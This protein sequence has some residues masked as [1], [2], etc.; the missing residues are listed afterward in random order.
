MVTV[1]PP[2]AATA[3][4]GA[5]TEVPPNESFFLSLWSNLQNN[6]GAPAPKLDCPI[7]C[8]PL[9]PVP[10]RPEAGDSDQTSSSSGSDQKPENMAVTVCGHI[11]GHVCLAHALAKQF[12][13]NNKLLDDLD[14][15][16]A[17]EFNVY[18]CPICKYPLSGERDDYQDDEAYVVP[19]C[20][21]DVHLQTEVPE[22]EVPLTIPEA[23]AHHT[24]GKTD[25]NP[26]TGTEPWLQ[27]LV[28]DP[29]RLSRV[30]TLRLLEMLGWLRKDDARCVLTWEDGDSM[31]FWTE[32]DECHSVSEED[33]GEAGAEEAEEDGSEDGAWEADVDP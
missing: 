3:A 12:W 5:L 17:A 32:V 4:T 25:D 15:V 29:D 2:S 6:P 13:T 19:I 18:D 8:G 22:V 27:E 20:G 11:F 26:S 21:I 9:K 31:Q 10:G 30:H 7:C 33:E 14:E 28:D 23:L 1:A 24:A 16:A